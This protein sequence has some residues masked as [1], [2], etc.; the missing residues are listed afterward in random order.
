MLNAGP[1]S[2]WRLNEASG[3]GTAASAVLANEGSDNATYTNVALGQPPALPGSAATSAT[4]NGTSSYVT[5]PNSLVTNASYQSISLWFKTT[6]SGVLFSYNTGPVTGSLPTTYTPALYV[7]ANG[8]LY[9]EFWY[10]GGVAPIVS[11]GTVN[12]GA[13]HHA[14]LSGGGRAHRATP[15]TGRWPPGCRTPSWAPL[16]MPDSLPPQPRRPSSSSRRAASS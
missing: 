7:G 15:G 2:Y 14:V 9:G 16:P 5:L 1:Q 10:D 11:P 13:W 8:K 12:D 6:G 3:A 4:F